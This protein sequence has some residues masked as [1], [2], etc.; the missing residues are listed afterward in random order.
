M[1]HQ[2]YVIG[3]PVEHSLSPLIHNMLYHWYNIKNCKYDYQEVHSSNLKVFLAKLKHNHVYGFNVTMPL[4]MEICNYLDVADESVVAGAN[5]VVVRNGQLYGYSTDASGLAKSIQSSGYDYTAKRIV[6]L[7]GGAVAETIIPDMIAKEAKSITILNRT[8]EKA[9]KIAQRHHIHADALHNIEIYMPTCDILIN[10]T[11]LGMTGM[12][13]DF[14]DFTFLDHLPATA[15][16]YD[17]IYS[18]QRTALLKNAQTRGI[19]TA[20]GL[21]MLIW[22]AFYA[23]LHFFGIMPTEENYH[24][25]LA[26]LQNK[27]NMDT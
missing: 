7:G 14:E 26:L 3:H 23:F 16:V 10:T 19:H 6:V 21:G 12:P 22:Q 5:T 8:E 20:N 11:P 2:Y 18:P 27:L 9:T 15:L 1:I 25:M 4:K 17:V 13:N 24:Q